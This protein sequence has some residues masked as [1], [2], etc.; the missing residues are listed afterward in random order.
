MA[1]MESNPNFEARRSFAHRGPSPNSET[2]SP[3]QIRNS[4]PKGA[5]RRQA[6]RSL[7]LSPFPPVG[8]RASDFGFQGLEGGRVGW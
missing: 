3:N 2:R 6:W 8:F 4:K 7:D 1:A 5:K